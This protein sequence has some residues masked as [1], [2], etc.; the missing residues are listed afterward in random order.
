MDSRSDPDLIFPIKPT[1]NNPSSARWG[2]QL[3]PRRKSSLVE[4]RKYNIQLRTLWIMM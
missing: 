1:A 3:T 2:Y 4:M